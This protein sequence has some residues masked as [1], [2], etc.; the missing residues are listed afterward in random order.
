MAG[1][2]S[3]PE[4]IDNRQNVNSSILENT[5]YTSDTLTNPVYH[6]YFSSPFLG[7]G[8]TLSPDDRNPKTSFPVYQHT[9]A[10]P[11]VTPS[12]WGEKRGEGKEREG[13][14]AVISTK[15]AIGSS[16]APILPITRKSQ[17]ILVLQSNTQ[18]K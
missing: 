7:V 3:P 17:S 9:K 5:F 14:G 11:L 10:S 13:E 15:S 1:I 16:T 6:I 8:N 12:E 4:F 2:K 18:M